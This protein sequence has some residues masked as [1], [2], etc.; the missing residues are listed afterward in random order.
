MYGGTTVSGDFNYEVTV[1]NDTSKEEKNSKIS[2]S[3][4]SKQEIELKKRLM[5]NR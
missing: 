4:K 3:K 2:K 1:E 5:R